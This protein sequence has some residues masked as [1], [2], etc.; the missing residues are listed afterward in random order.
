M[1]K[2]KRI[3]DKKMDKHGQ[4]AVFHRYTPGQRCP[5]YDEESGYCDPKWHRDNPTA[6]QCNEE[7]YLAGINE[8]LPIKAFIFPDS[9]F[10]RKDFSEEMFSAIGKTL[11]DEYIYVGKSDFELKQSETDYIEYYG[12]RF[13][14]KTGDIYRVGDDPIACIAKLKPVGAA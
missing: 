14:V 5:C 2:Y 11:D 9:D 8:T 3:L 13:E 12:K 10:N 6:P 1:S 7:G 4:S